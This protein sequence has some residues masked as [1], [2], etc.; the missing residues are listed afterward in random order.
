MQETGQVSIAS[1]TF[2]SESTRCCIT[3]ARLQCSRHTL[4]STALQARSALVNAQRKA[5]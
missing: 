3:R 4:V 2:S 1:C 5:L